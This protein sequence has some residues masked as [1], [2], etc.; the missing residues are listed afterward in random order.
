MSDS[1]SKTPVLPV[2]YNDPVVINSEEHRQA[3][4]LPQEGFAFARNIIA[5]PIALSEFRAVARHYPIVFSD[6]QA[7]VPLAVTGIDEGTNLFVEE[8]DAWAEGVYVPAY[9]RRYPFLF[10]K[11]ADSD[12]LMLAVERD[13]LC[14]W[15]DPPTSVALFEGDDKISLLVETALRFCEVFHRD[16]ENNRAFSDALTEKGLLVQQQAQIEFND[17]RQH[18]V[19][20]FRIPDQ[21]AYRQ[22]DDATLLDWFRR[23]WLDLVAYIL[24]SQINW[25][26]LLE[27]H[28]ARAERPTNKKNSK[29]NEIAET[30]A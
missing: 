15:V 16:H 25:Q 3:G 14:R 9:I 23:E 8:G 22:L 10:S 1:V 29:L 21:T 24:A 13:R 5:I 2:L 20:G 19:N 26:S 4:F 27:R 18:R 7:P 30:A 28:A 17:G 12:T 11:A 6:A